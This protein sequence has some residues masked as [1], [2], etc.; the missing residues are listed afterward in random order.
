MPIIGWAAWQTPFDFFYNYS[1]KVLFYKVESVCSRPTIWL[2]PLRG[3]AAAAGPAT[4][5]GGFGD[6]TG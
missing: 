4:S 1:T 3:A 5:Q 2:I 6:M